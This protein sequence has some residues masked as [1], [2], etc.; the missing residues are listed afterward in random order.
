MTQPDDPIETRLRATL[1]KVL[2]AYEGFSP[3]GI[4]AS[5]GEQIAKRLAVVGTGDLDTIKRVVD[6]VFAPL[7][8]VLEADAAAMMDELRDGLDVDEDDEP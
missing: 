2:A 7:Q 3:D 1:R 5:L 6:E 4:S 8:A